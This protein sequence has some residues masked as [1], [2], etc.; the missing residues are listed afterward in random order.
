MA[1]FKFT[2]DPPHREGERLIRIH[3]S[4]ENF[5][6]L[7]STADR[8]GEEALEELLGTLYSLEFDVEEVRILFCTNPP[9]LLVGVPEE[10]YSSAL[11][12]FPDQGSLERWI[13]NL[14]EE[15]VERSV[16]LP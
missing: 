9:L 4:S 7:V 10:S 16:G 14:T 12:R 3:L 8:E 1:V 5:R 11:S 15:L 2:G 13:S 6:R